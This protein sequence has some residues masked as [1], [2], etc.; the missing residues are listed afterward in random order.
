MPPAEFEPA[1]PASDR[2]Q[3]HALGRA[4]AGIHS[5]PYN[6]VVCMCFAYYEPSLLSR[7]A[8][9]RHV[10]AENRRASKTNNPDLLLR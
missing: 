8:S 9:T 6:S 10:I 2:P 3:T 4:A 7:R 5:V 1:V